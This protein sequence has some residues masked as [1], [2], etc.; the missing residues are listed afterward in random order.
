MH[1]HDDLTIHTRSA[2]L[3]SIK[4]MMSSHFN[5]VTA[6][7]QEVA[8]RLADGRLNSEVLV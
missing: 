2:I 7:L 3:T 6:S 1:S 5:P 8:Q 4:H